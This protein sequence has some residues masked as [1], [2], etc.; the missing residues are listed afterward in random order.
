MVGDGDV[1]P[2]NV[3]TGKRLIKQERIGDAAGIVARD[4]KML[5]VWETGG[6]KGRY[7]PASSLAGHPRAAAEWLVRK[8]VAINRQGSVT[9]ALGKRSIERQHS[10]LP[11]A[12]GGNSVHGLIAHALDANRESDRRAGGQRVAEDVIDHARNRVRTISV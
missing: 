7:L 11:G 12:A 10:P 5:A 9:G 4:D 2:T 6:V 8:W 3:G 1:I